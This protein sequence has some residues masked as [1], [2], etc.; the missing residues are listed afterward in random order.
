MTQHELC[1]SQCSLNQWHYIREE[2][3]SQGEK[4]R[5]DEREKGGRGGKKIKGRRE[6]GRREEEE[7]EHLFRGVLNKTKLSPMDHGLEK[8]MFIL[9]FN[10]SL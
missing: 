4:E 9:H 5:G 8:P 1:N 10:P 3:G 2:G 7:E 6:R